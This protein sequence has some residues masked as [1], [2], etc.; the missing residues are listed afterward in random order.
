MERPRRAP[1]AICELAMG[2]RTGG[3]IRSAQFDSPFAL[4][5]PHRVLPNGWLVEARNSAFITHNA[6]LILH[7][8]P[9][10]ISNL[11]LAP[12]LPLR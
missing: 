1:S 9:F 10:P 8:S 4:R 5:A 2:R 12:R 3:R 6:P 7:N 11:A